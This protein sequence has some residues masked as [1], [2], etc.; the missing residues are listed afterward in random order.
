MAGGGMLAKALVFLVF[1]VLGLR[2]R[3]SHRDAGLF[4]AYTIAMV[5][6]VGFTMREAWP[7]PRWALF[8]HLAPARFHGYV[9]ELIDDGGRAHPADPRLWQ[10]VAQE[11][12]HS[13][14]LH[15]MPRLTPEAQDRLLRDVLTRAERFRQHL[16]AGGRPANATILGPL[17]A[18]YHF[19]RAPLWSE[20]ARFPKRPFVAARIVRVSWDVE[21]RARDFAAVQKE[22]LRV[23]HAR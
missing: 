19:S 11:E 14:L 21:E 3:R 23:A 8:H 7:F 9:F 16:A 12:I 6:M 15:E 17:A 4:A 10:P 1:V 20:P 18:P 22:T 2:A 5:L 13:W